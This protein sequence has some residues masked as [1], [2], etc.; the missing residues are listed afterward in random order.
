M[1][2][3]NPIQEAS[4]AVAVAAG[5]MESAVSY[6]RSNLTAENKRVAKEAKEAHKTATIRMEA[7]LAGAAYAL[8]QVAIAPYEAQ[9]VADDI[10]LFSRLSG[11]EV[12]A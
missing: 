1:T 6:A 2:H 7:M 9:I 11:V 12:A 10:E 4:S 5:N 8:Q 3:K